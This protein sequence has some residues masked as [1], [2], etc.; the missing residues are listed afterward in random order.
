MSFSRESSRS[1]PCAQCAARSKNLGPFI[2]KE[3]RG[4][5]IRSD[6]GE[7]QKDPHRGEHSEACLSYAV[8][9]GS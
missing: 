4:N 6:H 9:G 3:P 2:A 5:A 8:E 1:E 7:E